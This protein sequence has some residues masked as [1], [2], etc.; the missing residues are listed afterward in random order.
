VDYGPI[1]TYWFAHQALVI[2]PKGTNWKTRGTVLDPWFIQNTK[3]YPV[4]GWGAHFPGVETD[5]VTWLLADESGYYTTGFPMYG[6]G[7]SDEIEAAVVA[8]RIAR[9]SQIEQQKQRLAA[10]CPV[11]FHLVDNQ[12][13]N[14]IGYFEGEGFVNEFPGAFVTMGYISGNEDM[15]WYFGLPE[16]TYQ[17]EG[18]GLGSGMFG[19]K[20]AYE[21]K[22]IFDYGTN[23]IVAAG[24][25]SLVVSVAQPAALMELPD[26][27]RVA[28]LLIRRPVTILPFI[29]LLLHD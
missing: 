21:D 9:R 3:S 27:S 26:G 23:P 25:A 16:G 29:P 11:N 17:M 8:A 19:L 24:T 12:S 7:Y 2:Y 14:R 6:T 22:G 28:P 4:Y 15:M 13:G 10:D 1:Q 18:T 20:T 5:L